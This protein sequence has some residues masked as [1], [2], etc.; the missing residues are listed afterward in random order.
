MAFNCMY[1]ISVASDICESTGFSIALR[2]KKTSKHFLNGWKTGLKGRTVFKKN[3][4][5]LFKLL[6]KSY[7]WKER[8]NISPYTTS[9]S[10]VY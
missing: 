10:H 5:V 3:A 1:Y 4:A 6:Q 9:S 2:K 8:D 7:G